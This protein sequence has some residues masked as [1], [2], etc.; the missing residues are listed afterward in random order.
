MWK[1]VLISG[2]WYAVQYNDEDELTLDIDDAVFE[3]VRNGNVVA[4][5]DD[6]ERFADE[7]NILVDDIVRAR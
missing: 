2:T 6:L 4:L 7:M 1:L 5:A 3:H